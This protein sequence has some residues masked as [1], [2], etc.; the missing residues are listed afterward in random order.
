MRLANQ[1]TRKP[2]A[3]ESGDARLSA[4]GGSLKRPPSQKELAN[5]LQV[6][7]RHLRR[8][9]E[10]EAVANRPCSR[11]YTH[12]DLWRLYERRGRKG[13]DRDFAARMGV[14]DVFDRFDQIRC[15][16]DACG[17]KDD[18][19]TMAA[20][21]LRSVA[22]DGTGA[23]A[24]SDSL[25]RMFGAGLAEAAKTQLRMIVDCAQARDV[26]VKAFFE[27]AL[28]AEAKRVPQSVEPDALA[29]LSA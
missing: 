22:T 5:I 3:A 24:G 11:P 29:A 23:A 20:M 21:M 18:R 16:D 25:P 7:T 14:A 1:T 4:F 26:L 15:G 13:W 6:T 12:A 28:I 8:W 27:A 17:S 9:E 10:L 19:F 2:V